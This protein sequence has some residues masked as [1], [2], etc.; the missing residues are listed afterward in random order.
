MRPKIIVI[1]LLSTLTGIC[2]GF[3]AVEAKADNDP[4][5][6]YGLLSYTD[7]DG[8]KKTVKTRKD[9]EK[10]RSR[11]LS[12]M[13]QAMG[14][15]PDLSAAGPVT[16]VFSDSLVTDK[17]TRYS[18]L[19]TVA[20]GE[21]VPAYY[22][23]PSGYSGKKPLPAILA[24]HPTGEAGKGLVDG[25]ST[26]P[27]R[28]YGKELA[29]RGYAVLAPDFPGYGELKDY[30]FSSDRYESGSMKG[31]FNHIR[32]VDFLVARPEVDPRN[33]GVIGHSLG[34]YNAIFVGAFEPRIK[35]VI[36]SSGWTIFDFYRPWSE[37]GARRHGG[38]LGPWAQEVHMPLLRDQYH[39]DGDLFPFDLHEAVAAIAPRA[40]FS[41]SPR[42]DYFSAEG[43]KVGM[44]S[45]KEVYK[46][47][48]VTE[49]ARA[50]YPEGGHDFPTE[51]RTA[52]YRFLDSELGLSPNDH[53]IE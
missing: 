14:R 15:L 46:L 40:F 52:A 29:E 7:S 44:E 31:I 41:N 53:F 24:L 16:A 13:Q 35:V 1:L 23:L 12:G 5:K 9:W 10:K 4:G 3:Y 21:T 33:I 8:K 30:D 42:E 27:N 32:C 17:Y 37:E 45:I 38:R 50:V 22:Y 34:G 2:F 39:L 18:V 36:S 47:Y 26:R 43:V 25:L 51:Q 48:G 19:L 6:K 28:A 11:I 49:K 20:P